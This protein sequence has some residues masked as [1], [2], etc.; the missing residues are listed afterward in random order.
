MFSNAVV[1]S[2]SREL[3]VLFAYIGW[4]NFYDGTESI[5]GNFAWLAEHPDDNAEASAFVTDDGYFY[6]GVGRGA[7]GATRLHVVFVAKDPKDGVRKVVAIYASAQPRP[8]DGGWM[9]VRTRLACRFPLEDRPVV[10]EWPGAQGIRRWARRTAGKSHPHLEQLFDQLVVRLRA[11]SPPEALTEDS[12][13]VEIQALEGQ[14]RWRLLSHRRREASLRKAKL[15][16]ALISGRGRLLCEVP[17][18]GFDFRERYGE[19]GQGFAQV[20]HLRPLSS[21]DSGGE[22]TKLS[23]LAILCANCHAMVH[24]GG[25]SRPLKGLIP[26]RRLTS[27]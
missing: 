5:S 11:S 27:Q 13:D 25:T 14:A 22:P 6:C 20:H 7:L 8:G 24:R 10:D 17:G 21:L 18:C 12:S 16:Q 19:L 23:D 9:N 2:L 15:A 26:R 3:P 1:P 4:A